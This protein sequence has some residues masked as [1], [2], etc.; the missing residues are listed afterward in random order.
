MMLT[1]TFPYLN[2]LIWVMEQG[3]ELLASAQRNVKLK[4][5]YSRKN[6]LRSISD[7]TFGWI[8]A[9]SDS[10][11][12]E[13]VVA[14]TRMA[15]LLASEDCIMPLHGKFHTC[16]VAKAPLFSQVTCSMC[17]FSLCSFETSLKHRCRVWHIIR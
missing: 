10:M 9:T 17:L 1:F 16:G 5:T 6:K 13:Q 12:K 8:N 2:P 3:S 11:L 15:H 4:S 7:M 14:K